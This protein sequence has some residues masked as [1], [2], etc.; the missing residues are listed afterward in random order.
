MAGGD[1]VGADLPR[2][3][4]Q[5]VELHVVV[6]ER[7]RNRRAAFEIIV[8]ERA[9]HVVFEFALEIHHVE[10]NAEMLGDAAR[11]VDVVD[12]AAAMLRGAA[13]FFL[14]QAA[15]IPELHR[16]ADDRLA[17][18][19]KHRRDRG[20]IDAAAHGD[21]DGADCAV[22]LAASSIAFAESDALRACRMSSSSSSSGHHRRG[23]RRE[24]AEAFDDCGDHGDGAVDFFGRGRAAEAEA[25]ARTGFVGREADREQH[26][27]RLD[28]AGGASRARGARN[29]LQIERDEQRFAAGGGNERF[30]VFGT[31][32]VASP[33]T[34]TD[35][36]DSS[37]AR[38]RGGRAVALMR[39]APPADCA[40]ASS[41]ALPRPTM[42]GTFSVPGRRSRS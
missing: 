6:A 5:L 12:R 35:A 13:R 19:V 26:V 38:S 25:Q 32:R 31:R 11:V 27:R 37:D 22:E 36:T 28:G 29:A 40:I 7:A 18:I 30:V 8:D 21:G 15:L 39:A 16:E 33:F 1:A 17:A 14:R 34:R 4:E 42:P 20:A 9:D 10:R 24:S 41:A 23:A 2:G 3:G